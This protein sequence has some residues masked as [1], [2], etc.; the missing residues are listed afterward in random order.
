MIGTF[1]D[2]RLAMCLGLIWLFSFKTLGQCCT[3]GSSSNGDDSIS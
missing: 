2:M 1:S 3:H